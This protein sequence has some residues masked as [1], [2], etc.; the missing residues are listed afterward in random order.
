[1]ICR[2]VAARI[3]DSGVSWGCSA[4]ALVQDLATALAVAAGLIATAWFARHYSALTDPGG[5]R[6]AAAGLAATWLAAL[7][8]AFAAGRPEALPH[9]TS[10]GR[11][12]VFV[13]DVSASATRDRAAWEAA[14]KQA[15]GA[16]RQIGDGAGGE[17]DIASLIVFAAGDEVIARAKAI[18]D[19]RDMLMDYPKR[20]TG[21]SSRPDPDGTAPARA[22]ADALDLI[23]RARRPGEII[24][25]SD[26]LWTSPPPNAEVRRAAIE[27][28][29]IHVWP[30]DA[31]PPARGIV[32]AHLARTIDSGAEAPIR[33]VVAGGGTGDAATVGIS[34]LQET[35]ETR[36]VDGSEAATPLRIIRRFDGRGL[37]FVDVSLAAGSGPGKDHL[38]RR[39]L[40]TMVVGPPRLFVLG[41]APWVNEL[42]RERFDIHR[43]DDPHQA[44]D[45]RE[46]DVIVIDGLLAQELDPQTPARI[47]A[48][49]RENGTGLFLVNGGLRGSVR[50]PTVVKSYAGTPIAPLLPVTADPDLLR[51]EP[52]PR[53]VALVIDVS[54]SMT[55]AP[56]R[57][58]QALARRIL[59]Q[60]AERDQIIIDTFPRIQGA[61][62]TPTRLT[63]D[64]RRQAERYI[65]SL[66]ASGGSDAGEGVDLVAR[67]KGNACA[68]FI[69]TDGDVVGTRMFVPG[70]NL[71]YLEIGAQPGFVN[72]DLPD[73]ARRNGQA[74]KIAPGGP[75]PRLRFRF[76]D[77][78]PEPT[79]FREGLINV[80]SRVND[81]L[82][83]P[84]LP[85]DGVAISHA[86]PDADVLV[87]RD[88]WPADP[89]LAFRR[90]ADGRGGETGVFMSVLGEH[91]MSRPEGREA[92]TR[93]LLRLSAWQD[94]ERFEIAMDEFGGRCR[95]TIAAI[96]DQGRVQ[97]MSSLTVSLDLEDG[98]S[99][100]VPLA[101]AQDR[102]GALS[103]TFDLPSRGAAPGDTVVRGHLRISEPD[104]PAQRIP[105]VLPVTDA[106]GMNGAAVAEAFTGGQDRAALRF[107]ADRTGGQVGPKL[108]LTRPPPPPAPE[109]R[110]RHE[111]PLA[112]AAVCAVVAFLARGSRL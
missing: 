29:P 100:P 9:Q 2:L 63:P 55:G 87:F 44:F 96:G 5:R 21:P 20:L 66:Y 77:P 112:L 51:R 31:G 94:R 37:Q 47:A 15:A 105:V 75:A 14:L 97:A 59:D 6:K 13:V 36:P 102:A 108:V 11:H 104:H 34:R 107:I 17:D 35:P 53:T 67:L 93:H 106:G 101:P 4:P 109:P 38:Q 60:L 79:F 19:V 41:R 92:I 83:A 72:R 76:F 89:V 57:M 25:I 49:V 78:D 16:T 69:I 18:A 43:I 98:R 110:P 82:V 1:M 52:P 71:S 81:P 22:L 12:V 86:F 74:E 54:G 40:Y 50:D 91:W 8:L 3:G 73:T 23:T 58:A 33:L 68:A 84:R 64:V 45:P 95:L 28:V 85:V 7:L 42:P 32:A 30:L 70:C 56:E 46:A 103:G 61:I 48:A 27:G 26:G 39:R 88:A 24:L 62:L 99:D 10:H 90:P 80:A 111:L 65:D